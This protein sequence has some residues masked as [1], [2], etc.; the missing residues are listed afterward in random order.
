MT[1]EYGSSILSHILGQVPH[2]TGD[3]RPIYKNY[4]SV[5]STIDD[6]IV[7]QGF[8]EGSSFTTR[9][10]YTRNN[11]EVIFGFVTE[12]A[13]VDVE[14]TYVILI[15]DME[16]NPLG[17]IQSFESG[18]EFR[19]FYKK[20]ENDTGEG[21]IYY[22][23]ETP[24]DA[25]PYQ[26]RIVC[27]NDPTSVEE[28]DPYEV[29]ILIS[30][31]IPNLD[32]FDFINCFNKNP[33]TTQFSFIHY[34]GWEVN[35]LSVVEMNA[36][37]GSS[38][39][40]NYYT[41]GS[42]ILDYTQRNAITNLWG[43]NFSARICIN[44]SGENVDD[45][46]YFYIFNTQN[47]NDTLSLELEKII[48]IE[49]N[50]QALMMIDN[51]NII[52]GNYNPFDR[53]VDHGLY[54]MNLNT[55]VRTTLFTNSYHNKYTIKVINGVPFVCR[56]EYNDTDQVGE[57]YVGIVY[58]NTYYE[59]SLNIEEQTERDD[60]F[61]LV[62]SF[63]LYSFRVMNSGKIYKVQTIFNT[64]NYNGNPFA[65]KNSVVSNSVVLENNTEILFARNLYNKT[66]SQNTVE[67]TVEIP[68][69]QLNGIEIPYQ[70]LMSKNNDIMLVNE[71]TIEKNLYESVLLN[72]FN[73]ITIIDRNNGKNK[74]MTNA[75]NYFVNGL[76]NGIDD[77]KA[78]KFRVSY[79]DNST[80]IGVIGETHLNIAG[81][82]NFV[83]YTKEGV[84]KIEILSNDESMVY[85]TITGEFDSNS[86]YRINQIVR[87]IE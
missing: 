81:I 12:P 9:F 59:Y 85:A 45:D 35:R 49:Q 40:W 47:E 72:F 6:Y 39:E 42:E 30:Y 74:V 43:D 10:S 44:I 17:L 15:T 26:A 11:K 61:F 76:E 79:S 52:Y 80:F 46:A 19:R 69:Y 70:S 24:L 29:E 62:N 58:N 31:I 60:D 57:I 41:Y 5:S 23:D 14:G 77:I 22:I 28:G 53:T 65:D 4:S 55:E 56:N 34:Y 18:T 50:T 25:N 13:E 73:T 84:D 8:A 64:N 20:L 37:V 66:I 32:G 67:S 36:P 78:L 1:Q 16:L 71:N 68:A 75:S 7:S 87:I 21:R 63:N 48:T 83:I 2:Q 27:I 33:D 82:L 86:Y 54:K 38:V 3:N 51:N